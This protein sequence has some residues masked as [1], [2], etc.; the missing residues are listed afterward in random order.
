MFGQWSEY[1]HQIHVFGL[2]KVKSK[3]I[4]FFHIHCFHVITYEFDIFIHDKY[5]KDLSSLQLLLKYFFIF[6]IEGEAFI[7]LGLQVYR[8]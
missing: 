2:L 3:N 5:Y 6:K 7:Q 8:K 4:I 1:I